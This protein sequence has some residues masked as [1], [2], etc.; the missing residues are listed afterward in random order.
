[1]KMFHYFLASSVEITLEKHQKLKWKFSFIYLFIHFKS[2]VLERMILRRLYFG[3][4]ISVN[5]S[6]F[7]ERKKKSYER[8]ILEVRRKR[9]KI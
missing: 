4:Y 9:T 2:K 6:V 5:K 1:M 8:M 3:L 7:Q